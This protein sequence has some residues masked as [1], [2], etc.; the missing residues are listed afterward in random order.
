MG[1]ESPPLILLYPADRY[2]G[3]GNASSDWGWGTGADPWRRFLRQI[4]GSSSPCFL[5]LLSYETDFP[6]EGCH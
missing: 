5:R 3:P 2:W 4:D 1:S 6:F